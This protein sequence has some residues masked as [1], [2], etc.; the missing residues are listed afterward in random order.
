MGN[1]ADA[2]QGLLVIS[3]DMIIRGISELDNCRQ[4]EIHG[5]VEGVVTAGAVR[6]HKTG[7]CY[8]SMKSEAPRS[9]APCRATSPSGT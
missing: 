8:G 3:E 4:L 6:I 2:N 5:S 1:P 7:K 9:W